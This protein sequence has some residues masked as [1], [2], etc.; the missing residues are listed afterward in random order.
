MGIDPDQPVQIFAAKDGTVYLNMAA[1]EIGD[2]IQLAAAAVGDD[3][4][5]SEVTIEVYQGGL[6]QRVRFHTSCSQDLRTGDR[7]G[8]LEVWS[9]ENED[10]GL[11]SF[12]AEVKYRYEIT[13][14]GSTPIFAVDVEDVPEP[15]EPFEVPG[16]PIDSLAPDETITLMATQFLTETTA[17]EVFVTGHSGSSG[18]PIC[19]ASD[20]A[21]VVFVEPPPSQDDCSDGKPR[22]LVF[23]YTGEGC[24][25]SDNQQ[26]SSDECSGD[27]NG[28]EPVRIVVTKDAEDVEVMPG[29]ESIGVGSLVSFEATGDKL[30]SNLVFA[31]KQGYSTKQ[32]LKIH[33][34]CSQPL[35]VGDQFGSMI[36]RAFEA[37]D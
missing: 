11:V 33:T 14:V 16:S 5:E 35:N 21:A 37:E 28:A 3:D 31:I 1:A 22:L 23:E 25:A 36:L 7:F 10:Q 8:G 15:G 27:P 17:N 4:L 32:A 6:V 24:G 29:D 9:F 13:N 20:M 30:K 34:S 26:G 18:G 12:G 19:E 2:V